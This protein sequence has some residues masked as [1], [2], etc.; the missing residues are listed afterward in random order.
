MLPSNAPKSNQGFTL[1]EV[2]IIV[3][4]VGILAAIAAPSFLAFL[5]RSRVNNALVAVE[6][7]FKEAQREAIRKSK[8][9]EIDIPTGSDQTITS[10]CFVTG[11]RTLDGIR[12]RLS[13]NTSWTVTYDFKGRTNDI[14]NAGTMFFSIPNTSMQEKCLVI[15]Q[16]IGIMRSGVFDNSSSANCKTK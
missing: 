12:I 11:P 8:S 13:K 16:G 7:A 2:L 3:I 1:P 9:C 10:D 14:S 6:G 15:S 4:I 5:N